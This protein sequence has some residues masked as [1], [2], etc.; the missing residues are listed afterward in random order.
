MIGPG[1]GGSGGGGTGG[2]GSGGGDGSDPIVGEGGV[3]VVV[4]ELELRE[5]ALAAERRAEELEERLAGALAELDAMRDAQARRDAA[6]ELDSLLSASGVLDL[7]TARLLA[8][9]AMHESGITPAEAVRELRRDKAFLFARVPTASMG[10]RLGSGALDDLA[11]QARAS[12][13]RRDVLAYL[14]RKRGV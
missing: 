4:E 7:E 10:A 5:R 1:G 2:S 12:G 13:D 8:E 3:P 9:R 14:R 6:L 11:E